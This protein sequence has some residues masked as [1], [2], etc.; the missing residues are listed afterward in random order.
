MEF[1]KLS[2]RSKAIIKKLLIQTKQ[3]ESF[4]I[5]K[6]DDQGRYIEYAFTKGAP[7]DN[8]CLDWYSS[9][10]PKA[11]ERNGHKVS[12]W[13]LQELG[14][15]YR[16]Y[17]FSC[18]HENEVGEFHC[19]AGH[20]CSKC[21]ES[22]VARKWTYEEPVKCACWHLVPVDFEDFKFNVT[23]K[24]IREAFLSSLDSIPYEN[25]QITEAQG[26]ELH[27]RLV[28]TC[29]D[30]LKEYSLS[31]VEEVHFGADS[32]QASKEEGEWCPCTDSSLVLEGYR[33]ENGMMVRSRILELM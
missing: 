3:L 6:E 29:I 16:L 5:L 33:E 26:K 7:H 18:G 10:Q 15:I 32:L 1:S 30:F 22:G 25:P 14:H 2:T 17:E 20:P 27:N 4:V 28:K 19:S 12:E 21:R 31:D 23:V 13:K 11:I 24:D 8:R 9:L